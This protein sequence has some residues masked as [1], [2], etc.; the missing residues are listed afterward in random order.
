MNP[1]SWTANWRGFYQFKVLF[2]SKF[3]Y[4]LGLLIAKKAY[5]DKTLRYF[6]TKTNKWETE[7][8]FMKCVLAPQVKISI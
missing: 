3:N 5:N 8:T 7:K 4:F 1:K 6:N 2:L